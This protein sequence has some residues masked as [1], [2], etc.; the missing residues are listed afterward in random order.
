MKAELLTER[1]RLSIEVPGCGSAR[2]YRCAAMSAIKS[3]AERFT[4]PGVWSWKRLENGLR[5]VSAPS[6]LVKAHYD[7]RSSP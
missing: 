3:S 2:V 5:L 1:K 4:M 6:V 7:A